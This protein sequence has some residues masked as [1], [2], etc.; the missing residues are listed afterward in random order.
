VLGYVRVS[1]DE[2][3]DSGA[4]LA[5]QRKTI[6][7]GCTARGYELVDLIPDAGWSGKDLDRPGIGEALERLDSGQADVL[8]VAKLDRLS[9]SLVDFAGLM[10]RARHR[11][12]AVIALD[13]GVDTTTAAGELVANV[14]ASV[15]QWER[16][17]IGART[18]EALDAKR[19]AGVRL[20]RPRSVPADVAERILAERDAG[21]TLAAIA[22]GLN[23]SKVPTGRGGSEWRPSSVRAVLVSLARD[24]EA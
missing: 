5:A 16:R 22:D 9:R 20:G 19:A 4:G 1:T 13:L 3:A 8:M 21:K 2:Q 6:R 23:A 17:T 15:A 12:W 11:K 18:K 7:D 24:R 10:E 14:M